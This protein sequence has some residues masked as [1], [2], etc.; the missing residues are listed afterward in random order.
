[1]KD[2]NIQNS[3]IEFTLLFPYN[4]KDIPLI[5]SD[6]KSSRKLSAFYELGIYNS[7]YKPNLLHKLFLRGEYNNT[8]NLV[9]SRE[10]YFDLNIKDNK[11]SN[12]VFL[13]SG[14]CTK[15][16]R[17]I[18]QCFFSENSDELYELY[19][20][21]DS[22]NYDDRD[23]SYF[24]SKI[25]DILSLLAFKVSIIDIRNRDKEKK[26]RKLLLYVSIIYLILLGV[27]SLGLL[28]KQL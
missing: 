20:K 16:E 17:E 15:N 13:W 3:P 8:I 12:L 1:M 24:K 6:K 19:K 2:I 11:K 18:I 4:N 26:E 22:D 28:T 9:K 21:Y 5:Y 14:K 27:I 7:F 23:K 10:L 25:D